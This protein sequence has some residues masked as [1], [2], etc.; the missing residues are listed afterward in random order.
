MK[1]IN[2]SKMVSF[3]SLFALLI[4][5]FAPKN[6]SRFEQV[7]Y[8][9]SSGASL[10]FY[11]HGTGDIDRVKIPL[12]TPNNRPI[13]IGNTFTIEFWLKASTSENASSSCTEG[14]DTWTQGNII[15]DRDIFGD[16]D[17]GDYGISL[18][19]GV[20]AF[21]IAQ[22]SNKLT[23][24]GSTAVGDSVW[25]HI[26]VT[27]NSSSGIMRIFV[28]GNLD[29][30]A[31]GPTGNISYRQGRATSYPND[32][33]LVI[34]AEKHDYDPVNYPSFSGWIDELRISNVER[35]TT[36]FTPPQTPFNPDTNTIALYH[37][38]EANSG[39]CTETVNDSAGNAFRTD[40]HK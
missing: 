9:Q 5:M 36:S 7:A 27:R 2:L 8:A 14:P 13:N 11:G 10:R 25:H 18:A 37:F 21:G 32:P 30:Q 31:T 1:K 19:G 15:I 4:L 34:G 24:C 17:Y 26:A 23:I 40:L 16:G 35:Y 39:P 12:V 29:R 38:D 3:V 20:I 28:D 6:S 22:G 33:Y